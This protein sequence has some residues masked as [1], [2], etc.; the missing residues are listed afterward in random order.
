MIQ[1]KEDNLHDILV[2]TL[3]ELGKDDEWD[4]PAQLV[5]LVGKQVEDGVMLGFVD[6]DVP[7]SITTSAPPA[8]WIGALMFAAK[9][10][11]AYGRFTEGFPKGWTYLGTG[12]VAEAWAVTATPEDKDALMAAAERHELDRH[13]ERKEVR[14][15]YVAVVGKSY[16]AQHVRGEDKPRVVGGE[17]VDGRIPDRLQEFHRFA[18]SVLPAEVLE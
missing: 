14:M 1:Y 11:G 13:P 7:E 2:S 6:L 16:L 4:K 15:L 5:Y 17:Q 10:T 3:V 9:S 8:E 18:L 12:V